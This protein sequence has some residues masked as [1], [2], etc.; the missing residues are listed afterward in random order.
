MMLIFLFIV[1]A[2]PLQAAFH[3][4]LNFFSRRN[5]L[6][7]LQSTNF[8]G[9]TASPETRQILLNHSLNAEL[10]SLLTIEDLKSFGINTP[11]SAMVM[12]WSKKTIRKQNRKFIKIKL[13]DEIVKF[14][15]ADD[16]HLQRVLSGLRI[17]W[18]KEAYASGSLSDEAVT[19]FE[20][21]KNNTLYYPNI[22]KI[23]DV[24]GLRQEILNLTRSKA[25][26]DT[27]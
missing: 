17:I 6:P 21:M 23:D 24:E 9:L 7:Q 11:E 27:K 8:E 19:S 5:F 14:N 1:A 25:E 4:S 16:Q 22:V 12:L 3:G 15:F 26:F 18:L 10:V 2:F 20:D 13:P